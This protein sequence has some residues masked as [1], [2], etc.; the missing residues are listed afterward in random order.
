MSLVSRAND[1]IHSD[2]SST[3]GSVMGD[4]DPHGD[5]KRDV[6]EYDD[7]DRTLKETKKQLKTL[8]N[9]KKELGRCILGYM[10]STNIETCNMRTG[11]ISRKVKKVAVAFTKKNMPSKIEQF[12]NDD[13]NC[14]KFEKGTNSE[15]AQMIVNFIYEHREYKQS[16]SLNK[17]QTKQ[18]KEEEN[19]DNDSNYEDESD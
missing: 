10:K 3:S 4:Y 8:E 7:I 17:S 12:F 6:R 15:K 14:D 18:Q 11:K 16:D 1:Y 2:Q 9:R 19:Y 13:E 5:F